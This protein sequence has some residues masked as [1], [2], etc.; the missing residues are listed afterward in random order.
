MLEKTKLRS[1]SFSKEI[2][3]VFHFKII[4]VV[5]H[6]PNNRGCLP[7]TTNI[8]VL[9]NWQKKLRSFSTVNELVETDAVI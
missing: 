9:L 8:K 1:S 6:L 3:V 5:F 4:K 2:E 7:F